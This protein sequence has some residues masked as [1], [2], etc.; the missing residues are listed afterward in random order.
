MVEVKNGTVSHGAPMASFCLFIL[1]TWL[2]GQEFREFLP[3]KLRT[4]TL[5]MLS[6]GGVARELA[7]PDLSTEMSV[8]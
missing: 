1:R 5:R 4:E 8:T 2:P 6:G 3:E 7:Q